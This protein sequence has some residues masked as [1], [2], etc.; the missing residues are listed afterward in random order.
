MWRE[1]GFLSE[2]GK[3]EGFLSETGKG[4]LSETGKGKARHSAGRRPER[5]PYSG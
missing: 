3:E 5:G 2:T 4:F 1:E